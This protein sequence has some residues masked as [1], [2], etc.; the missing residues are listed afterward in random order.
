MLLGRRAECDAL[1]RLLTD[2]LAGRSGV[3]VL[4][5]DPGIGKSA[6]LGYLSERVAGW[7]VARAVGVESEL[8]L[9]Y[10]SLH[11]ICAPLLDQLER[12]P[13]PQRE[14]LGT[15]FGLNAGAAPDSP[16]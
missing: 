10:S 11:Q 4:R 15:V 5:G 7:R 12:L 8:E 16:R 13:D 14:A 1:D 6:L 2:A 3:V 9:A